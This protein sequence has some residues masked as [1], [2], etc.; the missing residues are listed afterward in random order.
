MNGR[1]RDVKY[2]NGPAVATLFGD[3]LIVRWLGG[4][5]IKQPATLKDLEELPE[6][7]AL[8]DLNGYEVSEHD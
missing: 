3:K 7:L 2:E 6:A 4:I 5:A 8:A 1:S